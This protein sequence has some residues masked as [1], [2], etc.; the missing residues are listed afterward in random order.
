MRN[1]FISMVMLTA[2]LAC[3][4]CA[5]RKL[6]YPVNAQSAENLGNINA[7]LGI[8]RETY[9]PVLS[10]YLDFKIQQ[11]RVMKQNELLGG[12]M[13]LSPEAQIELEFYFRDQQAKKKEVLDL[14][15]TMLYTLKEQSD[16]ATIHLEAYKSYAESGKLSDDLALKLQDSTFQLK[17][18]AMLKLDSAKAKRVQELLLEFT[19]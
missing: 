9:I 1:R 7:N 2:A 12:A 5:S 17:A 11:L 18:L 6:L 14:L 4:G 10:T 8:I 13:R 3:A 19:K 15:Q 16:I